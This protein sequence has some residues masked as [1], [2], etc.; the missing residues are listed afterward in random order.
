MTTF[1]QVTVTTYEAVTAPGGAL[2]L[3]NERPVTLTVPPGS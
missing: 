2:I 1:V 3:T